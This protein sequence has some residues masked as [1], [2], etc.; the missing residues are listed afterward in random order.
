LFDK[1]LKTVRTPDE[2][3][4]V[5]AHEIAHVR[6][7]HV[8]AAMIRQFGIGIVAT[9]LGGTTGGNVDGFVA[10]D[11]SRRAER[12][13]DGEAIA[14]LQRA[15]ISPAPTAAFFDRLGKTEKGLGRFEPAFAYLSS[16]PLSGGR[17]KRFR[18]AKQGG[19]AYTPALTAREWAEL[20]AICS[21]RPPLRSWPTPVA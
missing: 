7:R 8:T 9:A 14:G 12:E 4:G 5:L 13:A 17:A 20:R 1:L 15:G 6:K 3:A 19:V 2:L 10:L 21:A 16:H 18:T 11:F